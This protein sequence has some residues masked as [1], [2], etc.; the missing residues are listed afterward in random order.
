[1]RLKLSTRS[2]F[3]LQSALVYNVGI[4]A[5][6][7]IRILRVYLETTAFNYF[8]DDRDGREDTINLFEAIAAG[9]YEGYASSYVTDELKKT[10]DS[11]RRN[12][13]LSL[14]YKYD[15]KILKDDARADVLADMYI[16]NG[17][18]PNAYRYDGLH[19]AISSLYNL[20]CVVSYNFKHIN[21]DET[22]SMVALAN[23]ELGYNGIRI[24][25]SKEVL[26]N[27][28]EI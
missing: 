19:I 7:K 4:G 28:D 23:R 27:G 18:I 10:Q 3:L 13:L 25:T 2:K 17:I 9:K 1:M 20:D 16:E 26:D 21:R 12:T 15:I 22:E 8:F 11:D 14:L 5:V 6:G 24:C